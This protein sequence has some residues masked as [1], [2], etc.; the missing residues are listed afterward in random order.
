MSKLSPPTACP[1]DNM[2]GDLLGFDTPS[3]VVATTPV[4]AKSSSD[5][6]FVTGATM[7]GDDFQDNWQTIPDTD[8]FVETI[9][10]PTVPSS[11]STIEAA[12]NGIGVCTMASGELPDEFKLFFYAQEE[13]GDGCIVLIQS[14]ISKCL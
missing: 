2:I 3:P 8:A 1:A 9:S 12:L 10:L 5:I 11:T 13:G 14:N 7:S 6:S 4:A